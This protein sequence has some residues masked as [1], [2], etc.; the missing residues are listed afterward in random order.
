MAPDQKPKVYRLQGIP[1]DLRNADE[2]SR[3]LSEHCPDLAGYNIQI[4]SLAKA[5]VSVA[6]LNWVATV[7]FHPQELCDDVANRS[8]RV[9]PIEAISKVKSGLVI[10]EHFLGVTPFN[11]VGLDDYAYDCIAVSGI[12]SHP[13]GSWQVHDGDKQFMWIRDIIPKLFPSARTM[14][15]GY[16]TELSNTHSFQK[17]QDL[18]ITFINHLHVVL[19]SSPARR[20]IVLIAHSLGGIVVKQALVMLAQG[21]HLAGHLLIQ[22]ISGA[23]FFGV[24]NHGMVISH[25]L[26]L[27]SGQPNHTMIEQIEENAPYLDR[28]ESQFSRLLQEANYLRH[29]TFFWA[30]ETQESVIPV[31]GH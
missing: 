28:L 3:Y 14:I 31:V 4:C 24:P 21:G 23:L 9:D 15:Y 18:A 5:L 8:P 20:S 19:R 12:G 7:M 2:V 1:S 27:T 25:L 10:D 13:F 26:A 30:Y 22:A 16:D 6:P 29:K 17:I 11:D